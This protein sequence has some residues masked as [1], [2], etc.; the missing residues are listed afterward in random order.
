MSSDDKSQ[1]AKTAHLP[2]PP[3]GLHDVGGGDFEFV[4]NRFLGFLKEAGLTPG[5]DVLDMGCGIG[6][7]AVPLTQFLDSTSRYAGFDIETKAIDWC[8]EEVVALHEGFS[9]HFANLYNEAYNPK[10][11]TLA[12]DFRFP[13]EDDSFDF[14]LATS[15]FTHLLPKDMEHYLAEV[16]RVL[17]PDGTLFITYFLLNEEIRDRRSSWK[18]TLHFKFELDCCW[19]NSEKVPEAVVA[20]DQADVEK[21]YD[22][23]GLSITDIQYGRWSGIESHTHQDIVVAS[24]V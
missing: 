23:A 1:A 7:I 14:A 6:R 10:S 11:T 16:V 5:D 19:V 4:G 2:V 9:F 8:N 22:A 3:P 15:L 24:P 18:R 17:R 20:Y 13:Y 12:Q 21:A